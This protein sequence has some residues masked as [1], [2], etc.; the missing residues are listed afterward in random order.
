M[1]A[2]AHHVAGEQG[3]LVTHLVRDP[4][5]REVGVGDERQLGL[6]ALQRAHVRSVAE[7]PLGVA[8]VIG[9]A[10]AEE[11]GAA[12][13]VKAAQDPVSGRRARYLVAHRHDRAHE[14]VAEREAGLDLDPPVGDVEIRAAHAAGLDPDDRRVV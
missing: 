5:Q 2:R 10:Q 6:G 11:A 13:G 9:A 7:R 8:L 12:G 14:L 3:H 4:S 1:V